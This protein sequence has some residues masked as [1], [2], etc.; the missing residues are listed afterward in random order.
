PFALGAA[1]DGLVLSY[2]EWFEGR[3][4][5]AVGALDAAIASARFPGVLPAFSPAPR[6]SFVD[7][8]YSD[9][10]GADTA[11][12]LFDAIAEATRTDPELSARLE[13]RLLLLDDAAAGEGAGGG[14]V[15]D[16]LTPLIAVLSVQSQQARRA[17]ARAREAFRRT[18]GEG[19]V[20]VSFDS[21]ALAL[22]LAWRLS[23]ATHHAVAATIG[24]PED[25]DPAR[26]ARPR[27]E[28][29]AQRLINL[30]AKNGCALVRILSTLG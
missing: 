1:S 5:P 3:R 12:K 23:A 16:A 20:S 21:Q 18:E 9:A 26:A 14:V 28:D 13:P 4:P 19:L 11:L 2:A 29:R 24:R 10:S 15:L 6:A 22:P 30:R 27:A 25:C 7:G 17:V 8:G